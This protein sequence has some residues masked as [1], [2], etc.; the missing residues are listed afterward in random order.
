MVREWLLLSML[1][2]DSCTIEIFDHRLVKKDG[3][4]LNTKYELQKKRQL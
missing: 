1:M 4:A 2:V 3:F